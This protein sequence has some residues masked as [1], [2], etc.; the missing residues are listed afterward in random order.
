MVISLSDP[1]AQLED[2]TLEVEP[3][4]PSMKHGQG[5]DTRVESIGSGQFKVS[6]IYFL[7]GGTWEMRLVLKQNN[8]IVDKQAFNVNL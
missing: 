7:M 8:N 4:M 3:Y 1:A 6:N 2:L 5:V